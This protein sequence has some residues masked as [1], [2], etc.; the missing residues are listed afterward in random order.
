[1]EKDV[2]TPYGFKEKLTNVEYVKRWLDEIY[3]DRLFY[4]LNLPL[5]ELTR[6]FNESYRLHAE[7]GSEQTLREL[8]ILTERLEERLFEAES[9]QR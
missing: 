2:R 9:L 7:K 8:L 6:R 4:T 5:L 3:Q 1:M